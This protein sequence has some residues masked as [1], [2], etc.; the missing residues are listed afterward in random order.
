MCGVT[1]PEGRESCPNCGA[2]IY[3]PE[4]YSPPPPTAGYG[5]GTLT[6]QEMEKKRNR[7]IGI[8]LI[9]I[10]IIL[11]P[12]ALFTFFMPIGWIFCPAAGICLL[13]GIITIV[14]NLK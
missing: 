12:V 3:P 9:I 2:R 10:S 1:V 6:E 13:A 7:T 11:L 5:H 4:T 8:I 14:T